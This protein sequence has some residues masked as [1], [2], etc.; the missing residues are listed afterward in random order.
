MLAGEPYTSFTVAVQ[1]RSRLAEDST[2]DFFDV[3]IWDA[4]L[5]EVCYV[6]ERVWAITSKTT[7]LEAVRIRSMLVYGRVFG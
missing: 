5:A 1:R 3:Y 4:P 6:W 2:K 7:A